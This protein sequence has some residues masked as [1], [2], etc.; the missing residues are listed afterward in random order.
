MSLTTR[1]HRVAAE[2]SLEELRQGL[3]ILERFGMQASALAQWWDWIQL[4]T[5]VNL[6]RGSILASDE[7]VLKQNL[8]Q[9]ELLRKQFADYNFMVS[10]LD[11]RINA[12]MI[13]TNQHY[14]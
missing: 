12:S 5:Q 1:A 13:H 9:W 10:F 14:A 4:E 2:R 11:S 7:L 6:G 8:G 3:D